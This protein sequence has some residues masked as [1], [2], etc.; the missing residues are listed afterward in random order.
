VDNTASNFTRTISAKSIA[1]NLIKLLAEAV[2]NTQWYYME[3]P[4]MYKFIMDNGMFVVITKKEISLYSL[5]NG[6]I[7]YSNSF[8]VARNEEA[9]EIYSIFDSKKGK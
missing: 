6:H 5:L 9:L 3:K 7:D 4:D 2:S 8:Q 1:Y